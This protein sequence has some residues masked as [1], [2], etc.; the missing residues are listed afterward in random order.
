M[1]HDGKRLSYV[2]YMVEERSE[3]NELATEQRIR[4]KQHLRKLY[5]APDFI[6]DVERRL[7]EWLWYMITMD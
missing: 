7:L 5:E 3:K 1:V 2:K 4:S 6:A